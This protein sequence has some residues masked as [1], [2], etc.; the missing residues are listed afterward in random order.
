[1]DMETSK[2]EQWKM[3]LRDARFAKLELL[4]QGRPCFPEEEVEADI[5]EA[6]AAVRAERAAEHSSA[7]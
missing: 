6:I 7:D 4:R 1:M 5:A 3:E 2:N